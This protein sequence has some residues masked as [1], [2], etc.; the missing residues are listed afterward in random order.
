MKKAM[1]VLAVFALA[2]S[3]WAADPIIGTWKLNIAKSKFAPSTQA[4]MKEGTHVVRELGADQFELTE[5][6]TRTDSSSTS[7]RFTWPQKGGV[8]KSEILAEGT[9]SIVTIIE[10]GEWYTTNLRNGKQVSTLHTVISKDGKTM[11]VTTKAT[12][13]QGKPYEVLRVLE[14]Q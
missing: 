7:Y 13:A 9:S 11:R 6:Q 5:T 10:P 3:L 1:L 14:K 12:D 8:L 4:A 2:G